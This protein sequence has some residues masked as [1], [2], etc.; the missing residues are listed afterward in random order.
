MPEWREQNRFLL[1]WRSGE[2]GVIKKWVK[3]QRKDIVRDVIIPQHSTEGDV[4]VVDNVHARPPLRG[5]SSAADFQVD[6]RAAPIGEDARKRG[7]QLLVESTT[8]VA[9]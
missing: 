2:G 7:I 6:R 8:A 4:V 9:G 1:A 5:A 3:E